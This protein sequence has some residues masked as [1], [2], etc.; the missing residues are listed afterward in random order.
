[1]KKKA[2]IIA[3][4]SLVFVLA[5]TACGD[6]DTAESSETLAESAV[7]SS[8]EASET[9]A[10]TPSVTPTPSP[11]ATPTPTE[12]PEETSETTASNSGSDTQT[13]TAATQETQSS[14]AQPASTEAAPAATEHVHTWVTMTGYTTETQTVHHDGCYTQPGLHFSGFVCRLYPNSR[15][16]TEFVPKNINRFCSVKRNK[17]T[18]LPGV[19]TEWDKAFVPTPLSCLK[20]VRKNRS[21]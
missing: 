2:L 5:L 11:T 12:M 8:V 18:A 3:V 17:H 9:E 1:M 6:D 19:V 16:S 13:T 10:V 14:A 7:E 21:F 15:E 4:I 20:I